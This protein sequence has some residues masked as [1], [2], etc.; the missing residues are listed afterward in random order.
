MVEGNSSILQQKVLDILKNAD[1]SEILALIKKQFNNA[2][3]A[4][5]INDKRSTIEHA[6]RE[7]LIEQCIGEIESVERMIKL[8]IDLSRQEIISPFSPVSLLVDVFDVSTLDFCERL[9]KF[10]ESNVNVFKEAHFF[11]P[12]K[13][14]LLRMC[15]D[16]L[17]R[18]SRS[19]NTVFCG[20]ILM[21]LAKFFPFSERSG[22]NIVSEFN[23]ENVTEF[24][25]TSAIDS[26]SNNEDAFRTS[27]TNVIT[28]DA[29]MKIDQHLYLKFWALQEFFRCPY[30]CYDKEKFKK[31]SGYTKDVLT[32]F[33][34]FKLEETAT[35]STKGIKSANEIITS[36]DDSEHF[37]AKF[38]TNPKLLALQMG[39]SNFRRTILVQYLILF[40]YLVSTVK[41]KSENDKL[42]TAQQEYVSETE[43]LVY[44]LLNETP[45]KS[46][47]FAEAIKHILAR[48][49]MW[50]SWKN[51]GC[52]EIKRP[53]GH[54]KEIPEPKKRKFLGDDI[55]NATKQGKFD[56]GNSELSRLWNLCPDNLQAC[57]NSDRNFLPSL[58]TY[59]DIK[60]SENKEK[61]DPTYEWRALRL[62]SRQSSHFFTLLAPPNEKV[63]KIS[64][65]LK[66]FNQKIQ[67]DK[68][69]VKAE[70]G[71]VEI[72][73]Q[74]ETLIEDNEASENIEDDTPEDENQHKDTAATPEQII[75]ISKVIGEG[76][77]K[78]G[79]KLGIE[80]DV[81]EFYKEKNPTS[82]CELM[83]TAWF[84]DDEDANL[85]NLAYTLEGL[86]FTK[87]VT[88]IKKIIDSDE[89]MQVD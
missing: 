11:T 54:E 6:L 25:F 47:E 78:L 80:K 43:E 76:W 19:Q 62:V 23:I 67:K 58:D 36:R 87:A 26:N 17:R 46:N 10:V 42:T 52:R 77:Q 65:Y 64:D 51:E 27:E 59:L 3:L 72:E 20:R 33:K 79:T 15:N 4:L 1:N 61:T 35:S 32:A 56:L 48:E 22:L 82:P 74:P 16:L 30:I 50:N 38:L 88:L 69:E 71:T 13:N 49:E 53:E 57:K 21:F 7:V 39:D 14:S 2:E 24:E 5:E 41:F 8:S 84:N 55:L 86:E 18:L 12:C 44:K 31:F 63:E 68:V 75:E 37:F 45:P 81:L 40:Q 70:T 28:E 66:L 29:S 60:D 34:S 89:T 73:S 9:F 83:L 85:E